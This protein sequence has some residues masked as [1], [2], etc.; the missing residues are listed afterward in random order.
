ML[1]CKLNARRYLEMRRMRLAGGVSGVVPLDKAHNPVRVLCLCAHS[2]GLMGSFGREVNADFIHE[3]EPWLQMGQTP[4]GLTNPCM[5]S[6]PSPAGSGLLLRL[7][8]LLLMP[9]SI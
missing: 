3:L 4:Q 6:R 1:P 2:D 9:C 5:G 7:V 8:L